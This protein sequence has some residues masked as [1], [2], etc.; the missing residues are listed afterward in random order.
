MLIQIPFGLLVRTEKN[1]RVVN[2]DKVE[3][4]ELIASIEHYGVVENLV[5]FSVLPDDCSCDLEN[6]APDSWPDIPNICFAVMAG[7]RRYSALEFLLLTEGCVAGVKMTPDFPVWCLVASEDE[8]TAISLIENLHRAEM[9]PADQFVAFMQLSKEGK[10]DSEIA[11]VFGKSKTDVRKLLRLGSVAPALIDLFRKG[12]LD[13]DDMMAFAFT[14]DQERQMACYNELK[15]RY[16]QPSEIRRFLSGGAVSTDDRKVKFVGLKAYKKAGGRVEED[17]FGT[18]SYVMDQDILKGLAEKK[19]N[20]AREKCLADGWAWCEITDDSHGFSRNCKQIEGDLLNVPKELQLRIDDAQRELEQ[21]QS[22]G[23]NL[24]DE[25]EEREG[26]LDELLDDLT[27]EAAQYHTYSTEQKALAGCVVSIG[28]DGNADI[29]YGLVRKAD[30]KKMPK[31]QGQ[32]GTA[33]TVVVADDGITESAALTADL[34]AYYLQAFQAALLGRDDLADDML[35]YTMAKSTFDDARWER[36]AEVRL[37]PPQLQAIGI[38][39]TSAAELL[40]KGRDKLALGW[41]QEDTPADQFRAFVDLS[42]TEKRRIKTYCVALNALSPMGSDEQDAG[43]VVRAMLGFDVS[44]YW[45]PTTENYFS[46]ITKNHLLRIGADVIDEQWVDDH[47]KT[48]KGVLSDLLPTLDQMHT[49]M[50]HC[51]R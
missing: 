31:Q 44:Q 4:K 37:N 41:L 13:L 32:Q 3:D 28:Y 27:S 26:E 24:T 8:A 49:W 6:M 29:N 12:K 18:K 46:R 36:L 30:L 51:M 15:N 22:K 9:H 1:V 5:V 50:P 38:E 17:L 47:Q 7:G 16:I 35:V 25:D 34:G 23:H 33:D 42:K 39:E 2:P 14:D 40:R 20:A 21:L 45:R 10:S 43:S 11:K 48:Q 19:L